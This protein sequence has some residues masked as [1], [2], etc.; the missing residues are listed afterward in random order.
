MLQLRVAAHADVADADL[1]GIVTTGLDE[2]ELHLRLVHLIRFERRAVSNI[3]GCARP[4]DSANPCRSLLNC[5]REYTRQLA[6]D[7]REP[8]APLGIDR[9][10]HLCADAMHCRTDR[11]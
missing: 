4:Q 11:P 6:A 2:V 3:L 5:R 7:R 8:A 1:V 10:A 9:K